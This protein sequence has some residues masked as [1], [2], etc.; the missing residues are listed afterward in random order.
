MRRY[1]VLQINKLYYPWI[2]G[3]EKVV[4][5]IAEDLKSEVN[6]EVLVCRNWGRGRNE[7]IN[8]VKVMRAGSLGIFFSMP[9]SLSFPIM[10]KRLNRDIL[11][12]HLPFPLAVISYLLMRPKGKVVVTY[13]SD[14]VR[15]RLFRIFYRPFLMRF[16]KR[17]DSII[18]SSQ[19]LKDN[20]LVLKRFRE[21]CR[22][23]PYGI[24]FEEF[25][26]TPEIAK[27]AQGIKERFKGPLLLFVGRL[28]PYK[29]LKYLI[30]AMKEVE[31]K[32]LVIGEGPLRVRLKGLA[33]RFGIE[34]KIIWIG[35]INRK[36]LISYYYACDFLVLPSISNNEAFGIVQLEAFACGKPVISTDLPTGVPFVNLH[37]KT[38]LTIPPKDSNA[39]ALTI[40]R[41][42]KSPDLRE[43]YGQYAKER[44]EKEFT[45]ELMN[46]RVLKLYQE[47]V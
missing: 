24:D 31:A 29:G 4:Q 20:S 38:G 34:N 39:L 19:N 17:A 5:N 16:L 11:H 41:L 7:I 15:Q 13:H 36:D 42:L 40:N 10:L 44:V 3:V 18:T 8:N 27:R 9:L 1:K 35:E 43:K 28:V 47:L 2:G 21:K 33:K 23:I 14:I 22:V 46:Q 12:F 30:E 37:Q 6:M 26:L 25:R 45:K 32:L